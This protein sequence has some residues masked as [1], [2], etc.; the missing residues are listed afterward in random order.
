MAVVVA[1]LAATGRPGTDADDETAGRSVA[2]V[3]SDDRTP[4]T[5]T[6]PASAA[7]PSGVDPPPPGTALVV[8]PL[9]GSWPDLGELRLLRWAQS[10]PG[11]LI[12]PLGA[13]A[14]DI[15]LA[16]RGPIAGIVPRLDGAVIVAAGRAVYHPEL[17]GAGGAVDLGP[18]DR[19]LASD[20]ATSIW[21]VTE[22]GTADQPPAVREIDV[23][24]GRATDPVALPLDAW[25]VAGVDGGLLVRGPDGGYLVGRDGAVR[26]ITH[27]S[28][29]DAAG[30]TVLLRACDEQLR[31]GHRLLDLRSGVERELEI[32]AELTWWET[33]LSPDG[34]ASASIG[35][36]RDHGWRLVIVD[37]T[38]GRRHEHVL[39]TAGSPPPSASVTWSPDGRWLIMGRQNG[40]SLFQPDNVAEAIIDRPGSLAAVTVIGPAPAP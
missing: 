5:T 32:D 28:V 8:E 7:D 14:T 19:A 11:E 27:G 18:A 15:Q 33:H 4:S 29:I 39:A 37:F 23:V 12:D 10:G 9:G 24:A 17:P 3:P 31:C 36:D 38:T 25:P 35:H 20:R 13:V 1:G 6:R 34:T 2:S 40:L 16:D 22:A 21:L 30:T 26:R